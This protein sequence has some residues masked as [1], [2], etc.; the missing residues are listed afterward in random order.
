MYETYCEHCVWSESGNST[1]SRKETATES[2][3]D[4]QEKVTVGMHSLN[5]IQL[6][7]FNKFNL[8]HS[9]FL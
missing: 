9:H 4:N 5:H 2:N 1:W 3:L 8:L 7:D 6:Q